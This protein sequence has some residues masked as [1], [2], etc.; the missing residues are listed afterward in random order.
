[1]QYNELLSQ[2]IIPG[3][4]STMSCSVSTLSQVHTVQWVAQYIIPGTCSAMQAN[5][6]LNHETWP[7]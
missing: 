3:T 5:G 2:Y 4:Y 6:I 7:D 1:M